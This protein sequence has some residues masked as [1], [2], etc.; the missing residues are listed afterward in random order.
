MTKKTG[1]MHHSLRANINKR[2]IQPWLDRRL[3]AADKITLSQRSIFIVPSKT[4]WMFTLLLTLLLITAINY[5]NSLIYGL[6]FWLFSIAL[7]AMI[8]TYR[9]LSGL[10]VQAT[11]SVEGFSNETIEIPVRISSFK[12]SHYKKL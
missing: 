8:F 3:P 10:M 2:F 12:Q 5:Q 7:S 6:V 11:N 4:G 1:S 9:N